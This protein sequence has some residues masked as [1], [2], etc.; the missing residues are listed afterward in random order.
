MKYDF[1]KVISRYG[2]YCSKYDGLKSM[3]PNANEDS[4]PLMVA[5]MDFRTAEPILEALKK[6]VDFQMFGYTMAP[7]CPDY[8]PAVCNWWKK[9]FDTELK[10][11]WIQNS[12]GT[13]AAI[14]AAIELFTL[15]GDGIIVQRPVY[16]HFSQD[17]EKLHRV[18]VSNHLISDGNGNYQIDF[19]DLEEKCAQANNTMMILCSPANPVGRIWTSEELNKVAEITRRH[20]VLLIS[21]EVHCDITRKGEKHLPIVKAVEDTINIIMMTAINKTFNLAGLE[22]SNIIIPNP[23]LKE[24]FTS[25]FNSME[26]T[27]P[28]AISA[29]L[30]AYNDPESEN[31]LNQVNDYIDGNIQFAMDFFKEKMP[32]VKTYIPQATYCIWVDFSESGLSGDEIHD[33]IYNKANVYSQDGAVHDPEE[34][35][36]FQRFCVP[37]AR[38]VLKEALERIA[39]VFTDIEV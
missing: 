33:R 14:D 34:G 2:T 15:P 8:A 7:C 19:D 31:W 35:E 26:L 11:E 25:H 13:V 37:C 36:H 21:D 3:F 6:T 16:G 4:I 24:R 38:S 29:L 39:E 28:F 23:T 10:P 18:P 32:W 17:I 5:D 20:G 30:A 12:P 27:T 22:C 1:D 9:R